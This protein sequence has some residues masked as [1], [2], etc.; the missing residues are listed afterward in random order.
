MAQVCD[1]GRVLIS[2]DKI[3]H[4]V[5]EVN[6]RN[7]WLYT[8]HPSG[9]VTSLIRRRGDFIVN[10]RFKRPPSEEGFTRQGA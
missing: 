2:A 10:M 6:L 4:A 5:N 1:V 8:K 3:F 7:C 9:E